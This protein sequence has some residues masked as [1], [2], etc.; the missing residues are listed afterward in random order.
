MLKLY[1]M[2]YSLPGPDRDVGLLTSKFIPNPRD[3][4][5]EVRSAVQM[6][7]QLKVAAD[8]STKITEEQKLSEEFN[9]T[10]THADCNSSIARHV[11]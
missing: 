9:T 11:S 7:N 10:S 1:V 6:T 3:M 5:D 2:F 8:A 4:R